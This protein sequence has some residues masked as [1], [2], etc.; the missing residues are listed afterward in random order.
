MLKSPEVAEYLRDQQKK[1]H[2]EKNLEQST[3]K[4]SSSKETTSPNL[5]TFVVR[6]G[7]TTFVANPSTS[8]ARSQSIE[9]TPPMKMPR[10]EPKDT[11][12]A[13]DTAKKSEGSSAQTV[14]PQAQEP[15]FEGSSG[16][17][18]WSKEAS[19][20]STVARAN[21]STSK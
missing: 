2:L 11:A 16:P 4:A 14:S 1:I 7:I 3:E 8:R 21:S 13:S 6:H 5:G 15:L 10:I 12:T 19:A 9:G 18:I 20:F 17:D